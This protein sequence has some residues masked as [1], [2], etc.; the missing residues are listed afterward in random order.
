[1]TNPT[2]DAISNSI[3]SLLSQLIST[4]DDIITTIIPQRGDCEEDCRLITLRNALSIFENAVNG[5]K[6]TD[7]LPLSDEAMSEVERGYHSEILSTDTLETINTLLEN[8]KQD[9]SGTQD[10]LTDVPMGQNDE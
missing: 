10:E 2:Q 3:K 4:S 8:L 1:M 5:I 7:V 9:L 6:G